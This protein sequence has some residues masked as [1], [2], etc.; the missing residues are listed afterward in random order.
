MKV[1]WGLITENRIKYLIQIDDD[2]T[3]EK[4][5]IKER[6]IEKYFDNY[7]DAKNQKG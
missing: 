3:L 1:Q 2:K 6:D 4:A 7:I 5:G